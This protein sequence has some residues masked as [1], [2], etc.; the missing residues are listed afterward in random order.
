MISKIKYSTLLVGVG[1][2]ILIS[3]SGAGNQEQEE[4]VETFSFVEG[5]AP[6]WENAISQV[7]AIAEAM[8]EDAYGWTPHDSIRTFAGQ[9]MHIAGSSKFIADYFLLDKAPEGP[10]S[11]PDISAMTKAEIIEAV[12]TNLGEIGELYKTLS[13][14]ELMEK[15]ALKSFS[16][17][18]FTRMQGLLFI[19]DHV[20]NH[21]AKANLYVRIH[22][23]EPP[24]YGYY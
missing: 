7:V 9:L 13:D 19:H 14:Q 4:P 8:P 2:L 17:N 10:P 6:I 12:K 1:A 18:E 16:G 23:E 22:G 15:C 20:T 11:E 5:Y 24:A 3:C 21:K